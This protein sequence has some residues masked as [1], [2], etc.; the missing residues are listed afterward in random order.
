MTQAKEGDAV[1]V[2]YT[3]K[4]SDGEVFASSVQQA[5]LEFVI[6]SGEVLPGFEEAIIGMSTGG[7][8][9]FSVSPEKGFGP[10]REELLLVVG[11]KDLP[12]DLEAEVGQQLY[13]R[14][15]DGSQIE[16]T[17]ASVDQ[18]SLTLDANHP[19]AGRELHFEVELLEIQ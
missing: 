11:K 1:K 4:F 19:L 17:V 7:K 15:E 8:K 13:Y 16:L 9:S 12:E 14:R 3:G 5:P 6:G 10:R 2:H 18:D